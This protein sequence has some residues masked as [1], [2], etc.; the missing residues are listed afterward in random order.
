MGIN[1]SSVQEQQEQIFGEFVLE[2]IINSDRFK[3]LKEHK[4]QVTIPKA[5]Q[6]WIEI[7]RRQEDERYKNPTRPWVYYNE[8]GSTSIVGPVIKKKAQ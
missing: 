1:S 7:Y 4:N 8:D 2:Q 3:N 5:S 6:E